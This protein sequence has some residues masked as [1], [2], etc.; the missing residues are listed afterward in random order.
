MITKSVCVR[1]NV[2][3]N[4]SREKMVKPKNSTRM[5]LLASHPRKKRRENE[6]RLLL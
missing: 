2:K 3:P 6:K 5:R 1:Q 4:V